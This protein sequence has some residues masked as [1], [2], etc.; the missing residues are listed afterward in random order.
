[1]LRDSNSVLP[2]DGGKNSA[3][4]T[5][6]H[7]THSIPARFSECDYPIITPPS[8]AAITRHL[9]DVSLV[10]NHDRNKGR[11]FTEA[12]EL[13]A[14]SQSSSL[15]TASKMINPHFNSTPI[16]H[17]ST[18]GDFC[19]SGSVSSHPNHPSMPS[20]ESN[21]INQI[22]ESNTPTYHDEP[23]YIYDCSTKKTYYKGKYLGKVRGNLHPSETYILPYTNMLLIWW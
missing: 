4:I 14:I 22:L 20:L 6:R 9:K 18:Y 7:P 19:T 8:V 12:Q 17:H 16:R 15:S 13:S 2:S 11:R 21:P 3:V 10:P 1:M 23:T 5:N